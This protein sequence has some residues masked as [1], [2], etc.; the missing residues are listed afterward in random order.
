MKAASV[1][2]T[3]LTLELGGKSPAVIDKG[4][5]LAEVAERI[6]WGKFINCGQTCV[7]PDFIMVHEDDLEGLINE[8]KKQVVGMFDTD[9]KGTGHS[10]YY[11]RII[12]D[13]HLKRLQHLLSD[14]LAKG[15]IAE[16]GGEVKPEQLYMEPTIMTQVG[17]NM[18]LMEEEIFGPILPILTYSD[19]NQV[20]TYLN[21]KP[22]PLAMYIFTVESFFADYLLKHTSSGTAVINDCVLQFGHPGLPFGGVNSSGMGKA[23]GY[24]GFLAFSN[25]KAV[26]KQKTGFTSSKILY[27][28]YGYK[29]MK[30][31]GFLMKY[32]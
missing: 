13:H 26:L 7:A 4:C 25:E 19:L 18:D 14:G 30:I 5:D 12:N 21:A 1:H 2:M 3:S 10:P 11:G 17:P 8:L 15:A 9:G 32:I 28:P 20:I 23:H 16:Y 29:E 24:F 22:K 6:I 31:L 27:P